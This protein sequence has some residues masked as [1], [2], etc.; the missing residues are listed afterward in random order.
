MFVRCF[1]ITKINVHEEAII[2]T[3]AIQI[4]SR[5][6]VKISVNNAESA[7]LF[8]CILIEIFF[9]VIVNNPTNID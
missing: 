3:T 5:Q 8:S 7:F 2:P 1:K 9:K 4:L 6:Y